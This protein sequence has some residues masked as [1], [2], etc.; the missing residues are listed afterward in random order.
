MFLIICM[1]IL[2]F[3]LCFSIYLIKY[4]LRTGSSNT[5]G[6]NS[7]N[8]GGPKPSY[9][10]NGASDQDREKLDRKKNYSTHKSTVAAREWQK[11]NP[12]KVREINRKKRLRQKA[13][14][15]EQNLRDPE[16]HQAELK[17]VR[18]GYNSMME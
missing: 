12:E 17:K 11:K 6:I 13:R 14:K 15:L 4:T 3:Y 9:E 16:A 8:G 18:D 10:T 7:G 1:I 2:N 5:G